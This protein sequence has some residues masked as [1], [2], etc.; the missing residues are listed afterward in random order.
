MSSP[1]PSQHLAHQRVLRE[2]KE[3]SAG[4]RNGREGGEGT[5]GGR[6]GSG[7][8]RQDRAELRRSVAGQLPETGPSLQ[9]CPGQHS[10]WWK[11]ES[12]EGSEQLP[13]SQWQK[14]NGGTR[15]EAA[16]R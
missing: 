15:Q 16:E 2:S 4:E 14:N 8:G 6:A 9:S 3:R 1:R 11:Q 7:T 5:P 12:R 13:I 10:G